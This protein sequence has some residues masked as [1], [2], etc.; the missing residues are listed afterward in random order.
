MRQG[1]LFSCAKKSIAKRRY[2]YDEQNLASAALI[3]EDAEK[4]G[5]AQSLPVVWARMILER[6]ATLNGNAGEGDDGDA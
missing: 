3:L 6:N 4:H 2:I 1:N 5:G